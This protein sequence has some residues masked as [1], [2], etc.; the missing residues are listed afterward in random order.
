MLLVVPVR[1][2]RYLWPVIPL[3]AYFLVLGLA[4]ASAAVREV[5][6]LGWPKATNQVDV[7]DRRLAVVGVILLATGALVARG[8]D[9]IPPPLEDHPDAQAL[10][11]FLRETNAAE[12][13]RVV[14]F[15]PRALTW[16]TGIPAMGTFPAPRADAVRELERK[17]ISHV[18]FGDLGLQPVRDSTLRATVASAAERFTIVYSNDSFAVYRMT[19][20][21]QATTP[22]IGGSTG[23]GE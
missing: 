5:A 7:R 12:P 22:T 10:F 8:A 20:A 19:R 4:W 1:A 6:R 15:S 14:F 2:E 18:V 11:A 16:N 21:N 23:V 17:R 13:A 9:E 3:V